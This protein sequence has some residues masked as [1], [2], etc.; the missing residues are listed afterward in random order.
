M[1]PQP[2]KPRSLGA[3]LV[4]RGFATEFEIA[5]A[6]DVQ[7]RRA[8]RGDFVRLGT[9]LVE[10][11]IVT[12]QQ[13]TEVLLEQKIS[14]F[15]CSTCGS[16]YNIHNPAPGVS[17]ECQKCRGKLEQPSAVKSLTIVDTLRNAPSPPPPRTAGPMDTVKAGP[18]RGARGNAGP[19]DTIKAGPPKG[20]RGT[21]GPQD[22]IKAPGG[23]TGAKPPRRRPTSERSKTRRFGDYEILGEIAR[24]GMGVIYK[25]RQTTLDRIVALKTLRSEEARYDDAVERFH[26]EAQAVASLRHPNLVAV[27]TVDKFNDIHFFTMELVEGVPLDRRL[28]RGG[29]MSSREAVELLLPI[30]DALQYAHGRG[31][32]HRDLKPANIIISREGVPFLVDFGIAKRKGD[33][34]LTEQGEILGSV[35]YM[36][37]EYIMGDDF[38]ESCDVYSL[39]IVLYESLAGFEKLPFGTDADVAT[40]RLLKRIAHGSPDKLSKHI[41]N[42]DPKL[43][44]I[45]MKAVERDLSKRYASPGALADDLR[46]WLA[47]QPD[48]PG[49]RSSGEI[50]ALADSSEAAASPAAAAESPA[51][52]PESPAT[53]PETPADPTR[54]APAKPAPAAKSSPMTPVLALLLVVAL[55]ASALF[56]IRSVNLQTQLDGR[57]GEICVKLLDQAD[58]AEQ[59]GDKPGAAALRRA[60]LDLTEGHP[61]LVQL[62]NR[63]RG[64]GD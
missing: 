63:A 57:L 7:S 28:K 53:A 35:P 58:R 60:V 15:V 45:V 62:E 30:V 22:T 56:G 14:I 43:E 11:G 27:H 25:A 12:P 36:A 18:P 20:A 10:E 42:I 46:A 26:R 6:V 33:R 3:L 37:P 13:V 29:P 17:Y 48:P 54:P 64:T 16:Q 2:A 4:E 40:I 34:Q 19:Q 39:G 47:E 50:S 8:Q 49:A 38:S 44:A 41:P 55:A 5:R 23:P 61:E 24:G 59:N 52:A 9:V 21:A 31:V 32:C 1:K 51:A